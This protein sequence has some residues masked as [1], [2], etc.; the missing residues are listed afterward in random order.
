MKK[1]ER[2]AQVTTPDGSLLG[3]F[4]HDGDL[5]I[6]V[7]G[8]E[9]MSSRRHA[10][11]ERLAQVACDPLRSRP[12]ARVLIGGLGL[13]Y[14]LKAALASLNHDATVVVAELMPVI[15][16]WNR[17]PDFGLAA[18]AVADPRTRIE[19][20]DV[21][22]V[23]ARGIGRYDAIMLDA[24][25]HTTAMNTEGNSSLYD[26]TG[27]YSIQAAL[28]PGGAVVYWSAGSDPLFAKRMGKCGFDVEVMR[29]PAHANGGGMHALI[30]GRR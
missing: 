25:N 20:A 16:E 26:P 17:N 21:A 1:W 19:I 22:D 10:S 8:R 18:A 14:T 11:E 3:L 12:G 7:N 29:V 9:L 4:E 6:R 24:D 23:I 2:L 15:V 30:I 27:L 13:G 5:A 28:R